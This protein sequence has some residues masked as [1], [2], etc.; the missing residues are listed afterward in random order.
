MK[1]AVIVSG[2][3]RRSETFMLGELLALEANGM[4]AGV[5]AT[6]LGE[7]GRAQPAVN[8]TQIKH[9]SE[10]LY[11]TEANESLPAGGPNDNPAPNYASHDVWVDSHI[12]GTVAAGRRIMDLTDKRHKGMI[13]CLYIDG[14]V[15]TKPVKDIKTTDFYPYELTNLIDH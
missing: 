6:K 9:G 5:F 13:N 11:L 15:E 7:T 10:I 12:L 8:I 14:H 3:P 1:L 4:L 2:F